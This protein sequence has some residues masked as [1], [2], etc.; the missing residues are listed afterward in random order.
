MEH[1]LEVKNLSVS[2]DG[3][4]GEVQAV[5]DVSFSLKKGEVLAIVGESG[6]GKSV[7]CKSIMKL[8]PPSAKIKEGSI[9]VN[10][11]DI[12]CYREKEMQK[13]RGRVFSMI[14]QDPMTS[15]NPTIKIGKQIGEA[16]VIHNKNYTKE[17]VNKKVLELMELVGISHPKERYHQYPWQFSGGMRQRCVM[18]IALAADPDILFAD[19]PTT[20]L[21]VIIQAQILDL[22]REIQMKLGT[23]TI[24]VSHDLG[25]VARVADRVAVMYAGKIV[26]SG[27][28]EDVFYDP[29]HPYT[30]GLLSAMPD[31]G[32]DD[33]RLYTIPG[34]P[35]NL[36]HK[37]TGD[38]FAPRNQFALEI[39]DKADPPM[40]QVTDTHYAA[41]WL[42]D[43]RAPK[44]EMPPE[45]KER[46][47]RMKKE[48]KI[49]DGE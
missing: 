40:F 1:L 12:T 8:L 6:C 48:A 4:A 31:L 46:I 32:T 36:L 14:F 10:G 44:A 39:D 22:L 18:A 3:P 15:L 28:V 26:E 16:V 37:V 20:A 7:L 19:E 47:A 41:T 49:D 29:R 13:L 21:D 9:C 34:S 25:V 27:T 38:A 33:E 43:P 24:L 5:R 30:W 2:I 45:L 11:Q 23:A 17:Q 42:L 35:P